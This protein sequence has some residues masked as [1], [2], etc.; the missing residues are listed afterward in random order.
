VL[1]VDGEAIADSTRILRRIEAISGA[2]T[3]GLEERARAE[4]WL[5]ED[6][7]DT[8]LNGF[9]VAARWAHDEQ[10]LREKVALSDLADALPSSRGARPR[11]SYADDR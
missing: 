7:A 2:F 4:A 1:L 9:L 6:F 10:A 5:W 8:A 11:A 3:R